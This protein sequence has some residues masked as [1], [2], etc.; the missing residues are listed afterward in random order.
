[1][2]LNGSDRVRHWITQ[3]EPQ[4]FIGLGHMEGTHAPGLSLGFK[5]VLLASHHSLLAHGKSVQAIRTHAKQSPLIG[6][7]PIGMTKIPFGNSPTDIEA[8]RSAMFSISEKTIQVNSW[9]MDPVYLGQYPEDGIKLFEKDL[10]HIGQDDMKLIAQ[11]IDF[12]GAN[13]YNGKLFRMG[14]GG[15]PELV[16]R[17]DGHPRTAIGWSVSPEALYWGPKFFYERYNKPIL[18]TENGMSNID[19]VSLDGKVHDPQRIDFLSRYIHEYRKAAAEGVDAIGYFCWSL[20]DDFEWSDGY[21]ERFGLVHVD[22]AT[23]KRTIK[24]SGYWYKKVIESN[25]SNLL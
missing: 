4:C 1:M 10:P 13:I 16:R 25:G 22:Y 14:S 17:E 9:W 15:T 2:L 23:Q 24:D 18:I 8:A 12:F 11:P 20:M 6:Y 19:W 3:N 21:S 7:A 5:D